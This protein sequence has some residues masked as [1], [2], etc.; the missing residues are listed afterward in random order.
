ME[1]TGAQ[2]IR[3]TLAGVSVYWEPPQVTP[4]LGDFIFQRVLLAQKISGKGIV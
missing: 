2:G 1:L 4:V 3:E